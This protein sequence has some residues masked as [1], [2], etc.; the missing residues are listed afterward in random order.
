M[1]RVRRSA[2]IPLIM[3]IYTRQGDDG[4]SGLFGGSRGSKADPRLRCTGAIDELNAA[5][6]FAAAAIDEPAQAPIRRV[7]NELF[8]IGSH[9]A[10]PPGASTASLPPMSDT[11]ITHLEQEI[12][13]ADSQLPPLKNF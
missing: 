6:G 9:L 10:T 5:L 11:M 4:T 13:A 8:V 7:Q 2:T 1:N 3:K 12:D